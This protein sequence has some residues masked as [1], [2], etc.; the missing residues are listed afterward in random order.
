MVAAL[1][2]KPAPVFAV[3]SLVR[4]L[5]ARGGRVPPDAAAVAEA[6]CVRA[7][8]HAQRVSPLAAAADLAGGLKLTTPVRPARG[9][10]RRRQAPRGPAG[11]P[12]SPTPGQIDP[13][14]AAPVLGKPLPTRKPRDGAAGAGRRG[15]GR[16]HVPAAREALLGGAGR[17]AGPAVGRHRHRAGRLDRRGRVTL[18]DAVKD[19]KASPRLLAGE[20]GP[21]SGSRCTTAARPKP[22]LDELTNGL[23]SA[24]A[25][26]STT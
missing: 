13:A 26:A 10:R 1:K 11:R 2:E 23:P 12:P 19:G 20:G 6:A 14:K 18:L 22:R 7:M 15:A 17:G 4:G 8:K 21:R 9:V 24:D 3:Q 25:S 16:R 5:Q